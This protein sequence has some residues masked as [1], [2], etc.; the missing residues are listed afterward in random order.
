MLCVCNSV[1]DHILQEHL[2]NTTSLLVDQARDTLHT[3]TTSETTDS[4]LRNTLD[5][6]TK[7]LS[8]SFGSSFSQSLTAFTTTRH[9]SRE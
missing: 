5:V 9:D 4:W 8:M 2:E 1:T 3:T 7:N 6:V